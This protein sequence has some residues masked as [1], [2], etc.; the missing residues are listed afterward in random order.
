MTIQVLSGLSATM[1][2][3]EEHIAENYSPAFL[4]TEEFDDEDIVE[5]KIEV[6]DEDFD[7]IV[8]WSEKLEGYGGWYL[9]EED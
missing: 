8:T 6:N 9:A 4:E 1:E 2:L 3:I 5:I 7:K